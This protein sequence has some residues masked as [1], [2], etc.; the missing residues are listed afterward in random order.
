MK[1]N[2]PFAKDYQDAIKSGK[3]DKIID[4]FRQKMHNFNREK[5]VEYKNKSKKEEEMKENVK[6]Q[7]AVAKETSD[8]SVITE[9]IRETTRIKR[10]LTETYK[11]TQSLN[12]DLRDFQNSISKKR[13]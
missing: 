13:K 5:I 1:I 10:S 6:Q 3:S 11:E 2:N 4:E 7:F 9:Q 8:K 12:R